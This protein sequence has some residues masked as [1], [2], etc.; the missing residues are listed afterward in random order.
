MEKTILTEAKVRVE[1]IPAHK[2]IAVRDAQVQAYFPFFERHNCD[3]ICGV[4]ESMT[5][6]ASGRHLPHRRLVLRSGQEGI[7]LRS[8]VPDDYTGPVP[9]R[10]RGAGI[11]RKLLS[12]ILSS[13]I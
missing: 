13:R 2:Y 7:Y 3:E 6:D 8:G 4:I 10:V 11:S 5:H 12:G 9:W 1:Y